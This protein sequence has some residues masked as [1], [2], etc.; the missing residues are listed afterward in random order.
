MQNK[1]LSRRTLLAGS[2]ILG[3]GSA[4]GLGRARAQSAPIRLGVGSDPVFASFF[5]AAHEKLFEAEGLNV[6]LQ[7]YTE[8]GEAMN[9][10]IAGQVDLSCSSDTSSIIRLPR[11]DLR[12]LAV[13]Y[14]SGRYIKLVGGSDITEPAQIKRWGVV[15]GSTSE[16]CA[17]LAMAKYGIDE[18]TVTVVP[19][20]PPELPAL[21]ARDDVDGY[22]AWE[23][24]PSM[25]VQQGGTIMARSADVGYVDTQWLNASAG[26]ADS[27][28]EDAQAFLRAL[29]KAATIAHDE[30]S[31]AAVAIRAMTSI[32][33]EN[34]LKALAD[35]TPIVRDF[36]EQDFE[37]YDR[38]ATFLAD[39][40][41]TEGLVPW[42]DDMM[43]G[44]FKG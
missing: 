39:K 9:A 33:E 17:R 6:A 27:R 37:S 19:S 2:A 24:W 1:S 22:F 40:K 12:A 32:P 15:M 20:G 3:M 25:G 43:P 16:Y 44:F 35:I 26:F 36:T 41:V 30:P 31:R 8:G 13:V 34:S 23:P 11:G 7:T 28:A 14:Q 10:L 29:A 38:I 21:L 42:R 18:A 4:L 5:I